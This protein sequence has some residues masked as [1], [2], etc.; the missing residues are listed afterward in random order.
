MTNPNPFGT[1][2]PPGANGPSTEEL[3]G[4]LLLINVA[5]IEEIKATVHGDAKAVK[6]AVVELDGPDAGAEH[7]DCL[8]FSKTLT[9]QLATPQ[10][11]LGRLSKDPI[12]GGKTAWHFTG[13]ETDPAAVAIATQYLSYKAGQVPTAAPAA[14]ATPAFTPPPAAAA[15]A[16]A[17][18]PWAQG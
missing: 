13:A 1:P 14:P 2:A 12:P 17:A 7:P 3:K 8:L 6:C 11:Y 5:S 4:K 10:M 18:P 15:P 16:A 9:Q